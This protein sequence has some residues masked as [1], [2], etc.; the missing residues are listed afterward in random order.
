ME[1]GKE[2]IKKEIRNK[3]QGQCNRTKMRIVGKDKWERKEY[4]KKG[5]GVLIQK[6]IRIRLNMRNQT[7]NYR[8]KH[9]N[10]VKINRVKINLMT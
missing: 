6:I 4:T 9:I 5:N 8:N 10:G 7:R 2:K 1:K 3:L